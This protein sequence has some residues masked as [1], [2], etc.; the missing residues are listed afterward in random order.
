MGVLDESAHGPAFRELCER[1]AID[2]RASGL[3]AAAG[4]S[5]DER[6][7]R[8]E[9]LAKLLALAESP[10]P[11]EAEAAMA[12]AQRL[13]HRYNLEP[14]VRA[15]YGF[16]HLGAPTGRVGEADRIVAHIL[17]RH[18]FVEVIWVPVWRAREGK[19]G[20]VLEVCGTPDNLEMADYV[21]AFLRQSAER[22][23]DDYRRARGLHGNGERRQFIAGV[24]AGFDE[25]LDAGRKR[26]QSEGLVWIRDKDLANY[27]RRRHPHIRWTRYAGERHGEARS[28]GKEAGRRIVL[29][30]PVG[31]SRGG[32]RRLLTG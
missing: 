17:E 23:W 6:A 19:R 2:G 26:A 32:E 7:R 22:L 30:R 10:N 20:S 18:F 16:C 12:A 1:F 25:K 24:M 5:G 13:I 15:G 11:H 31:G 21:H 27:Y 9:R 14:P 28:D 8:L 4:R 3:P 29:H